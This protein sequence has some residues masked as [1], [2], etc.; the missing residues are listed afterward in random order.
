MTEQHALDICQHALEVAKAAGAEFADAVFSSGRSTSVK[1]RLQQT[2]EVTQSRDQALGLRVLVGG[3]GTLRTATT[4][5]SDL[6]RD[7]IARLVEQA[8]ALARRTAED[9]FSGPPDADDPA[10]SPEPGAP[11]DLETWD[12]AVFNLDAD[13]AVALALETEQAALSRDKRLSNSEGAELGWGFSETHL[14]DSRGRHHHKRATSISLWTTPVAEQ[15]GQMERDYWWTSAR[16]LGDLL[17]PAEVGRIAAERTLRRLGAR[18]PKTTEVPV[19]YE[20]PIASRILGTIGAAVNGGAIF[21]DA[22]YL[23]GK[24]GEAIAAPCVT[25]TDNPWIVRGAASRIYDGEGLATR[26]LSIV[27]RG[28]LQSWVLDTYSARKLGMAST[29]SAFRGLGSPGPGT[30]NLWMDNGD[31]T[32]AELIA[33]VDEGLFITD[34]F[35]GGA[36]TITGDYSQGA[37][38][39]WIE[40]GELTY[41][42]NELTIASTLPTLWQSISGLAN[43]RHPGKSTSAP[44][45]RVARMTVAG[46]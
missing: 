25:I 19:I 40:K 14:V 34:T 5:T 43:D 17:T 11:L 42:V 32:L 15:N 37:A 1:V 10:F 38:G 41:P 39:L 6:S 30:S 12:D 31:R 46:Q 8:V 45:F 22:S 29:R 36:N 26:P 24:L 27:D 35:G 18:K 20:A 28:V 3:K 7:A 33:E 9:P 4:T 44:S 23:I 16:H 21:R 13:R 2:E